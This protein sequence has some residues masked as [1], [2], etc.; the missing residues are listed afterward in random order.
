MSAALGFSPTA[1]RRSPHLVLN[2]NTLRI[3]T[4]NSPIHVSRLVLPIA[5]PKK[6]TCWISGSLT[7]GTCEMFDGVP[8][9]P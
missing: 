2:R 7:F 8:L 9:L 3:G 5:S 1:R 4:S 6:P